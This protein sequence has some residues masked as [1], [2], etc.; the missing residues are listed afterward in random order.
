MTQAKACY[1]H[2]TFVTHDASASQHI[3]VHKGKKYD[4]IHKIEA[5][6]IFNPD[7]LHVLYILWSRIYITN[8]K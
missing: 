3:C 2:T 5:Y 8:I 6:T 1:V 4:C 7:I